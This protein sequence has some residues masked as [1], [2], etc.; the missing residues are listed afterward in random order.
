[1][2]R[3]VWENRDLLIA[4]KPPF[5][6]VEKD[7]TEKHDML[8]LLSAQTGYDLFLIHRLDLPVG[9]LLL[10]AKNK[11]AA[12][13]LSAMAG[14]GKIEKRY[15]AVAEGSPKEEETLVDYLKKEK[16]R[17]SVCGS[18]EKDAKY[19]ELSYRRLDTAD[20][21]GIP[22]FLL[23]VSLKTGRFHQ[24]RCQLAS[25]G[26]ALLGDGKYGSRRS[27]LPLGLYACSLSFDYHKET[28][29]VFSYPDL[30]ALPFSLF[31]MESYQK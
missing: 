23:S 29:R 31:T 26:M 15:Y 18:E 2:I 4:E 30:S 16:N 11:K 17:S 22:V 10:F 12:A 6:S 9:G 1:M 5:V 21:D 20:Y 3:I 25:R 24:I 7:R 13:I 8:S 14:S 28:I 19:A 27:H